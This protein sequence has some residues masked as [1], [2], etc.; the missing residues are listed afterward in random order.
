VVGPGLLFTGFAGAATLHAVALSGTGGS[1]QVLTSSGSVRCEGC[2]I[3]QATA[4][5][6]LVDGG[7]PTVTFTGTIDDRAA[8]LVT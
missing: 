6:L 4:T 1:L 7:S 8:G 3:S 5:N 2:S